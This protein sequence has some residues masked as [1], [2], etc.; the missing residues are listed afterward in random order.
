MNSLKKYLSVALMLFSLISFGQEEKMIEEKKE[1][2]K[3]KHEVRIIMENF[4][5]KNN[6]ADP[7]DQIVNYI[8]FDALDNYNIYKSKFSYGLGYNFNLNHFGIRTR[9]YYSSSSDA[10]IDY[11]GFEVESNH[12]QYKVGFGLVYQKQF[13][14]LT[15]FTGIDYLT[16]NMS[17]KTI[18]KYLSSVY[19]QEGREVLEYKGFSIEPLFGIKCFLLKNF[20]ISTELRLSFDK[21]NA[22]RESIFVDYNYAQ[23]N[24]DSSFDFDGHDNRVGPNGTVSF[25]FHF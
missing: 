21:F 15:F 6:E 7:Y 23:N 11:Y 2:K 22:N 16:F 1:A 24:R 8:A 9:G 12:I 3:P 10:Y 18:T 13:K 20:S 17:A 14:K 19:N 25:N 5:G 4:F